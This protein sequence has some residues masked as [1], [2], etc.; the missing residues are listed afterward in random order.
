MRF[1]FCFPFLFMRNEGKPDFKSELTFSKAEKHDLT[2]GLPKKYRRK[3]TTS[4]L[5]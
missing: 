3:N 1:F 4:E 5:Q 2:P